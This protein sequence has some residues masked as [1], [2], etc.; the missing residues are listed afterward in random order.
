MNKKGKKI[1][2]IMAGILISAIFAGVFAGYGIPHL[3]ASPK[4]KTIKTMKQQAYT[5]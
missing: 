1:R 3:Y 5:A 2:H 4:E